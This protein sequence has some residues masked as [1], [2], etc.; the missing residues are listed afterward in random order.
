MLHISGGV[1]TPGIAGS[2]QFGISMSACKHPEV[3][4]RYGP[5]DRIGLTGDLEPRHGSDVVQQI[6]KN[7]QCIFLNFYKMKRRIWRQIVRAAA[8]PHELPPGPND[9]DSSPVLTSN[10]SDGIAVCL[11]WLFGLLADGRPDEADLA[12]FRSC[13]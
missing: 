8:G 11:M 4:H 13:K 5:L 6:N 3:F 2:G 10:S 1:F 7:D 9:E 12:A